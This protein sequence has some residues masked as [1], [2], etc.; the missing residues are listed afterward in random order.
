VR[1]GLLD[2]LLLREP[3]VV[4]ERLGTWQPLLGAPVSGAATT[5]SFLCLRNPRCFLAAGFWLA[6]MGVLKRERL[7]HAARITEAR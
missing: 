3:A 6:A 4:E 1:Y 7:H 5:R 2:Q